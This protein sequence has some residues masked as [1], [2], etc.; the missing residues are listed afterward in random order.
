MS[1]QT[2]VSY[3]FCESDRADSLDARTVLG[4]LIRQALS[5]E[6]LDGCIQKALADLFKDGDPDVEE[7][8]NLFIEVVKMSQSYWVVIDGL[9]ECLRADREAILTVLRKVQR[10]SRSPLKVF[11][12]AREDI[13]MDI[14]SIIGSYRHQAMSCDAAT[15]DISSYVKDVLADRLA[16]KE[17]VVGDP[18][19]VPDIQNALVQGAQGM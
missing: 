15:S 3:L 13:R 11:L 12:S 19:L 2:T 9:D 17:L 8:Q 16:R 6:M 10:A 1:D 5:I 4:C 7:L 18:T 14:E